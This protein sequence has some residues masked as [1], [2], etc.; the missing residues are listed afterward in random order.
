MSVVVAGHLDGEKM[1]AMYDN[2]G[3]T[4]R[5]VW[6]NLFL[7]LQ[8]RRMW[9]HQ[10]WITRSRTLA[11]IPAINCEKGDVLAIVHGFN[12]PLLL[13]SRRDGT[14]AVGGQCYLEDAMFG[15]AVTWEE[16]K[17]DILPLA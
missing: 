3:E 11:L 6:H 4:D 13:R 5:N 8:L 1:L 2:E 17:G 9:N 14:Y 10:V 12:A 7:N 16:D 15:E